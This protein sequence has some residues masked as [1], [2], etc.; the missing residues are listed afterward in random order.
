MMPFEP[1]ADLRIGHLVE[2]SGTVA[3]VELSGDVLEL[4]RSYGGRVYSIGQIGSVVKI[5]SG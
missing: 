4:T 5:H 3:R 1:T 2:V